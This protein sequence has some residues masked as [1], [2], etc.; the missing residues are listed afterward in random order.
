MKTFKLSIACILAV[1]SLSTSAQVILDGEFRPRMII[2]G[3]YKTIKLESDPVFVY[4]S[5]RSR[6]NLSYKKNKLETYFSI[7]D[8]HVWGDDDMYSSSGMS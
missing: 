4:I 1:V 7:Q 3:G 2:D 6:V 5:Q 8:V